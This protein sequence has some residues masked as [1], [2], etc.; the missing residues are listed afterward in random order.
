MLAVR[1]AARYNVSVAAIMGDPKYGRGRVAQEAFIQ[2]IMALG[3]SE[4]AVADI[5]G[6]SESWVRKRTLYRAA[7]P[8]ELDA[9]EDL[10]AGHAKA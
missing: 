5:Y 10:E 4:R 6:R 7:T 8:K 3:V 9:H 2:Q 1:I